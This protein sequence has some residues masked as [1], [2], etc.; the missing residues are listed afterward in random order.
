VASRPS[1]LEG[2]GVTAGFWQGK[3]VFLT[4]HTG[5][6]GA[7]LSLWL[8]ELGAKVRGYSIDVPTKP[9]LFESARVGE[10][11]EHRVGD[12]RNL[13]AL[14]EALHAFKPDVVFHLAAQALVRLSYQN[15][16]ETY[17][18]NVMGT[19]HVLEAVRKAPSARAVV[20]VT[21][22]KCYENIETDRGYQETDRMGG[23]DPY[24][25]SKGCAEL[26]TAAYRA[27]FFDPA[28]YAE[29]RVAVASARAGNVIGGGDWSADRLIPDVYRAVASRQ[30]VRIRNPK[31]VRPWQHVLEPIGGYLLLAEQLWRKGAEV[32]EGWNFGPPDTDARPVAEVMDRLTGV[33]PAARWEL[34]QGAHPHEA[35][36]LRLDCS[37]ARAKLGWR[38]RLRLEEALAWTAEWYKAF[39]KGDDMRGFSLGQIARYRQLEAA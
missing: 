28:K 20:V 1:T 30:P 17:A 10:S 12:V 21:S 7:W 34:D 38:P 37:K 9:S 32:A 22:D 31:A 39:M 33:W 36:L 29:H 5:F 35:M 24:S 3:K 8:H 16:V 13:P 15:P 6:K 23:R 14:G 18:T 26:V 19:A 25:N 11:L 2:L 4:G 27:S